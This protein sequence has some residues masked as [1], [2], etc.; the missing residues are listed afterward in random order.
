MYISSNKCQNY[1]HSTKH[2]YFLL[3]NEMFMLCLYEI[4]QIAYIPTVIVV[5]EKKKHGLM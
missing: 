5:F 1:E 3:I 4:I 2:T